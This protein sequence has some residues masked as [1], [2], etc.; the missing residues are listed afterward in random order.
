[1]RTTGT[2]RACAD[3]AVTTV[4]LTGEIDAALGDE[5]A[6]ALAWATA[7]GLPVHLD[8]ADVAFLD[9]TGVGFLLDCRRVCTAHGLPCSLRNVPA[10]VAGTLRILGLEGLLTVVPAQSTRP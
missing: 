3:G 4:T 7:A 5:S 6:S 8:L 9:S 1:M 10:R 2:I